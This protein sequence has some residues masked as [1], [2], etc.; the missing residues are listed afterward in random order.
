VTVQGQPRLGRPAADELLAGAH[1]GP[2][3]PTLPIL[4]HAR[5]GLHD[6]AV[7]ARNPL[8]G[9]YA[10]VA[11][12]VGHAEL[13]AA[14]ALGGREATHAVAPRTRHL[15]ELLALTE[16]EARAFKRLLYAAEPTEEGGAI[17]HHQARVTAQHLCLAGRQME[18]A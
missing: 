10:D 5:C 16:G 7:E 6:L 1:R 17:G 18:L 8:R 12:H 11:F 13:H 15:D 14:E 9:A 3:K 4:A 2:R